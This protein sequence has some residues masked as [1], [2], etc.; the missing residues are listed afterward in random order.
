MRPEQLDLTGAKILLVDDNSTN[1]KV[2]RQTL[3]VEG[4]NISVATTGE[5]GLK[6]AGSARPDLILLDVVMPGMDG[7]ETCRRLQQE[8][9]TQETPVIFI[10][11]KGE[12]RE[13]VEGFQAGG[14]DYV[15]KPFQTEEVLMRIKTH[16]ERALLARVLAEKNRELAQKNRELREEIDQRK[17]LTEQLSMISRREAERWGIAGF[18]GKSRTLQKILR[19]IDLLQ[20]SSAISVLITGESG[21]GKEL[22]ARAIHF[23]SSR[24]SGPFVPVNCS[25]IPKDLAESVLFG[26]VRGAFTGADAE[27]KGYFELAHHGTLFLDEIGDMPADLQAKL[28]RVLE[29]GVVAP[30]GAAEGKRV[31]VR[32]LA[33]TNC[34][35]QERIAAGAFRQDL[36]FRLARFAVVAPPLRERR[37][38]IPVLAEH[39]LEMFA[40]EMGVPSPQLG[41]DALGLLESYAFP[42]NVR[43]LENLIERALIESGGREVRPEHLH[44]FDAPA[45]SPS[46]GVR[47]ASAG[48]SGAGI[49]VAEMPL[50]LVEAEKIL[51]KRALEQTRGNIAAAARLLGTN[52]PHIYQVLKQGT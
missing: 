4:Y 24:A 6:I 50:N 38:D 31:E 11:A 20:R 40:A 28:L 14:V 52:R 17:T 19:D 39:F 32:V 23:G 15:L 25:A 29:D 41:S 13:V 45:P 1:L 18:I 48:G 10:T 21:T 51:I 47:P 5:Q 7:F 30:V 37:E 44:F 42:G 2:L 33:A 9:A 12:T 16:L 36:Y 35:L 27:R 3:E 34:D 46:G 49:A 8:A 43:E 22:I 26:H